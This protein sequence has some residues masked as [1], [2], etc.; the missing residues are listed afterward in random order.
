MKF[1][2]ATLYPIH[3][4]RSCTAFILSL[5]TL[6]GWVRKQLVF[7]SVRHGTGMYQYIPLAVRTTVR[8]S[9]CLVPSRCCTSTGVLV[10]TTSMYRFAQSCPG[11]QDSRYGDHDSDV[12]WLTESTRDWQAR[13]PVTR[14]VTVG[15]HQAEAG[16]TRACQWVPVTVTGML[17][18]QVQVPCSTRPES[19]T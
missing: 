3:T 12:E 14:A 7:L 1:N 4:S 11:V 16:T 8:F 17:S 5:L 19:Q 2:F 13:P 9:Y 15:G 6:S 10:R 18:F